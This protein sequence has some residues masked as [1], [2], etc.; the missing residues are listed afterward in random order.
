ML[1][2]TIELQELEQ[3]YIQATKK[4]KGEKDFAKKYSLENEDLQATIDCILGR[5]PGTNLNRGLTCK[6]YNKN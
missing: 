2:S 1:N 5:I 6:Q 4:D 3:E